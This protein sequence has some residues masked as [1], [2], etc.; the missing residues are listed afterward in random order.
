MN[1][2]TVYITPRAIAEIKDLPGNIKQRVKREVSLLSDNSRPEH[3]K[4]LNVPDIEYEVRRVRLD[5]WRIVYT[6]VEAEKVIDILTVRKRPP[7]DYGD[8]AV[9]LQERK[10]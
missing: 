5:R 3:S 9:L 10:T 2:Y 6:I 8:L 1:H 4:K 7:Y